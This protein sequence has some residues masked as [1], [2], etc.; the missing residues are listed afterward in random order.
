MR[1]R[2]F[3]T[4]SA[5][6]V[7]GVFGGLAAASSASANNSF[8]APPAGSP[9]VHATD[10]P[11]LITYGRNDEIIRVVEPTGFNISEYSSVGG[12]TWYQWGPDVA[13]ATGYVRGL[14]IQ[15]EENQY[16]D[17]TVTLF[18]VRDGVFSEFWITGPFEQPEY[19]GDKT[20]GYFY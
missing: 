16:D 13:I 19:P 1:R 18:D 9:N 17:V 2:A 6:A 14:W 7:A 15:N 12:L 5:A 3:A 4:A 20:H 8:P 10:T 11:V